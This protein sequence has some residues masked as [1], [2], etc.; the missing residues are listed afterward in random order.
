MNLFKKFIVIALA[1]FTLN[2]SAVGLA[3][4]ASKFVGNITTRGSTLCF[5]VL[6]ILTGLKG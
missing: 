3:E 5:G 1:A 6:N 4:N 2:A